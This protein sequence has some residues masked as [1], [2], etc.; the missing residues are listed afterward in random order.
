MSRASDLSC[1]IDLTLLVIDCKLN[2]SENLLGIFSLYKFDCL[3]FVLFFCACLHKYKNALSKKLC[4]TYF[5]LARK[6]CK[7]F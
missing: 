7:A 6:L 3:G 2:L 5:R 4:Q 1:S